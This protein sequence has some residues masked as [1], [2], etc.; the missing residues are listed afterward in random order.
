MIPA[1]V[2]AIMHGG[3]APPGS[4]VYSTPGSYNF[5]VPY[6]IYALTTFAIGGGGGG[7]G[8]GTA[9]NLSFLS[10]G[11]GGAGGYLSASIPVLPGQ[12]V[13]IV[14]GSG[15]SG[16]SAWSGA[17]VRAGNGSNTVIAANKITY[18]CYGG[19]GGD[20]S[21]NPGTGGSGPTGIGNSGSM[22]TSSSPGHGAASVYGSNTG[23]ISYLPEINDGSPGTYGGGGG[24]GASFS[25]QLSKAGGNGGAGYV[26]INW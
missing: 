3:K 21:G 24:S 4:I 25:H 18:T 19:N 2:H 10:G 6:G 14:V 9:M 23:G 8:G 11:G 22:G 16:G 1:C 12:T 15:G 5:T 13:S 17:G 7:G 20:S 26:S